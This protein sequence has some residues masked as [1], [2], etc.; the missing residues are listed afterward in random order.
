M[1]II[2]L[3][4]DSAETVAVCDMP[5]PYPAISGDGTRTAY[6]DLNQLVVLDIREGQHA[7]GQAVC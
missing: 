1:K 4:L 3:F 2:R 5:Y 7:A 6:L